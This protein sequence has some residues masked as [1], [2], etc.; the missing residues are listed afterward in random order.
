LVA[1][2][3]GIL[4]AIGYHVSQDD[5]QQLTTYAGEAAAIVG[6][7]VAIIGRVKATK[8]IRGFIVKPRK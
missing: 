7:V 1:V 3:A 2:A 4:P 6:G 5:M 8:P